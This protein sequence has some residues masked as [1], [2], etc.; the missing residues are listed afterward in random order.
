MTKPR[1]ILTGRGFFGK[2]DWIGYLFCLPMLIGIVVFTVYPMIDTF[3]MSLQQTNGIN[4]VFVGFDNYASALTNSDFYKAL[5]NTFYMGALGVLLGLPGSFIL[6]TLINRATFGKNFFKSIYFL[7]NIVSIVAISLIFK[8]FFAPTREGIINSL[9]SLF[10]VEPV[11]WLVNPKLAGLSV[12]LMGCWRLGYDAIIFLAGLQSVPR[13]LYEA[14]DIDGAGELRKWWSVTIP[15][16]KHIFSFMIIMMTISQLKRFGDVYMIGTPT[17][18]PSGSL[19]TMVLYIY[20]MAFQG[21]VVGYASA[22]AYILFAIIL[23]FT[24]LNMRLNRQKD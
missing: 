13:E 7:P 1:G 11:G 14:A 2:E 5:G 19:L 23:L 24:L 6:A 16:M 3:W 17:G 21:H 22:V 20:R 18:N 9:L 12:V 8:Y 10:G 15:C 4:G